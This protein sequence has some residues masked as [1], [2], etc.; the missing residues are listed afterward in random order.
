MRLNKYIALATGQSRRLADKLIINKE[1]LVNSNVGLLTDNINGND[2]VFYKRK[3]L[4]LPEQNISILLN[5]PTGYVSSRSGQ[6]NKS[7]YEL[8][9]ISF[10]NLKI[11]GRLDKNSE[12]LMILSNNGDFINQLTHPKYVKEKKYQIRLDKD[13]IT[14]DQQRLLNG[15]KL[16]DGLSKLQIQKFMDS[17]K[18]WQIIMTEGRNRQIRRTFENLGYKVV[19]LKRI[20][21]GEYELSNLALGKYQ[22]IK[23]IDSL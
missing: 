21:I 15:V 6:G 18:S 16:S 23:N 5:K 14:Q 9:P 7:V 22:L 4:K 12:G 3:L 19:K 20:S 13:L 8:L 17:R 11:S 1:I 10:A 2:L